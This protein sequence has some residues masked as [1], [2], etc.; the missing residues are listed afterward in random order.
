MVLPPDERAFRRRDLDG[1]P[2]QKPVAFD[3][4]TLLPGDCLVYW[5]P[6]FADYII[7]AKTWS[8]WCGHI[9]LYEG[10][11]MS[12][13][14]RAGGVNLYELRT[15]G[16]Q[17]VRRPYSIPNWRESYDWFDH[18]ARRC[19]YAWEALFSF[20]F[21]RA[22]KCPHRMF[23]SDYATRRYRHAQKSSPPGTL[24]F[25]PNYPSQETPPDYYLVSAAF[26]TAW[27]RP[28]IKNK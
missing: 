27:K 3:K 23:C 14:A 12:S 1:V 5:T 26:W 25:D 22:I 19:K 10:N 11:G 4:S 2:V 15:E 28:G 13:A 6:C 17:Y 18:E 7:S 20:A 21:A 9:E 8:R 16:L 24:A